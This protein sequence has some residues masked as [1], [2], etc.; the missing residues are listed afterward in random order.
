[1]I[2]RIVSNGKAKVRREVR[3]KRAYF[4]APASMI[5]PG[6]IPGSQGPLYYP[7][8][9][10]SRGYSVWNGMP[11]VVN[12]PT[13][14]DGNYVSARDPDVLEKY[15]IGYVFRANWD[16][17]L[18]A[19]A[20]IDEDD[21]RRVSPKVYN[22]LL[23][24]QTVEL[25]TGLFTLNEE[26]PEG[27]TVNGRTYTHVVI[28]YTP[29]HLA[30]LPEIK[31][32]CSLDDGCGLN[33]NLCT[34]EGQGCEGC[35]TRV[36]N[37]DYFLV[38]KLKKKMSMASILADEIEAAGDGTLIFKHNGKTYKHTYK[39][40]GEGISQDVE[41]GSD[42]PS[43]VQK[44]DGYYRRSKTSSPPAATEPNSPNSKPTGN[45][46]NKDQ[47]VA[48]L[49]AN[50]DAWKTKEGKETLNKLSEAEL[51][52][53]KAFHDKATTITI[54]TNAEGGI[55]WAK[56]AKLLGVETDQ[57][58]EP[59]KFVAD[60]K[61]KME[62]LVGKLS[63]EEPI[64]EPQAVEGAP[65]EPVAAS[66]HAPAPNNKKVAPVQAP[67]KKRTAKEWL[68]DAPPEVAKAVQNAMKVEAREKAAIIARLTANCKD[69][70]AKAQAVAVYNTMSLDQLQLLAVAL[71]VPAPTQPQ[72]PNIFGVNF[73]D[74]GVTVPGV[75]SAD[76]DDDIL[77]L[78]TMNFGS[79]D[80]APDSAVSLRKRLIAGR[81]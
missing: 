23:H 8:E 81:R 75:N 73:P 33:V 19:E 38:E 76:D 4:V 50:C 62:E 21:V 67:T 74:P 61:I 17:K 9:R 43:E 44:I 6:V 52:A 72:V 46:M 13:D 49:T 65:A 54:V 14:G 12:H 3:N 60:L 37:K 30:I 66:K 63:G 78:P 80:D 24:D 51:K 26:A 34:C 10:F 77:P 45:E 36:S 79:D 18:L 11:V 59:V 55:D 7:E 71:P 58:T 29:D 57:R 28:D 31:G 40:V 68:E 70:A 42:K 41:L 32:A 69:D 56:L 20:W 64:E 15:G 48:F 5:V 27:A 47:L 16:D 53:I 22:A 2:L 39:I 25:S 1:M 35:I